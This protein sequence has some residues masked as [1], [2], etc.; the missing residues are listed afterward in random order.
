MST[1]VHEANLPGFLTYAPYVE[2]AR[3]EEFQQAFE[4][5]KDRIFSLGYYM[6]GSELCA[7]ELS[8][9]VFLKSFKQHRNPE[10]LNIDLNLVNALRESMPIGVLTLNVKPSSDVS[11]R[12][13]TKRTELEAAVMELPPTERMIFLM[14]D[15]EGYGHRRI[16]GTIGVTETESKQGLLQARLKVREVIAR[17]KQNP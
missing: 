7:E 13:N 12:S 3:L 11:V 16:A 1:I 2:Q 14:H 5:H 10:A 15:V 17:V 9:R 4:E 8:T 6:T